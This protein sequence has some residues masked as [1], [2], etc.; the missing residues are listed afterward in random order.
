V[1]IAA[2]GLYGVIAYLVTQRTREI[3][4]R[5]ALGAS[6]ASVL[7]LVLRRAAMLTALG[8][9]AGGA[10]VWYFGAM[11]RSFLFQLDPLEPR[12]LGAA[13]LLMS[14]IALAAALIP[15]RRAASIDPLIALRQD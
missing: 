13:V 12:V 11:V 5:M 6:R 4:V 15:A 7:R 8:V 14:V 10:A 3:G 1:L 9:S 2:I